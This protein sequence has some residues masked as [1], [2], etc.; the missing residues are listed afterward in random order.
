M[1]KIL[2]SAILFASTSYPLLTW[3][4]T[5]TQFFQKSKISGQVRSYYFNRLYGAANVP[6]QDAF[7]LGGLLDIKSAPFLGGFG[8]GVSFYTANDLGTHGY[9]PAT[10]D[11]TMMGLTSSLNALGQAYI[12]YANPGQQLLVRA[13][14]QIINTPWMNNSDARILPAT[15]Q[16][17]FAQYSPFPGIKLEALREFR[18]K[19]RTSPDYYKDNLYY[20]TGYS[21]D[22]IY[23]GVP[24]L[25]NSASQAQGALAFSASATVVGTKAQV[26][27]YDFYHFAKMFYGSAQYTL[28]TATGIVDPLVGVQFVREWES[29]SLLNAGA[30]AQPVDNVIGDTVNSSAWGVQVGANFDIAPTILGKGQF[31]W[32]YN[33]IV[34]HVGAIGGGAI[35]SPYTIGYAT[36]PLYTTS[37]IRGLVEMGPGDGWKVKWIQNILHKQFLWMAAFAR[38]HTYYSGNSNDVY[39]DLTYFP[40]GMFKGLSVRDRME[41]ANGGL[42]H[43]TPLNPGNKTFIYNRVM[44][45]YMF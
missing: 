20:S 14:D 18:W 16:A 13:G 3:A 35:V 43:D 17:I 36:D 22:P 34:P 19:S 30:G 33:G 11:T 32:S 42:V 44:L 39:V 31:T 10:V 15:Y 1:N 24:K 7:A 41:V 12:Q 5:L 37:M 29:N 21:G 27:Y 2:F 45:T 28:K 23:G 8:V 26:W 25:P 38:Y 40:G 6:N 4:G 9:S